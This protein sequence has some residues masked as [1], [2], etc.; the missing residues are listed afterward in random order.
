MLN[1]KYNKHPTTETQEA[2]EECKPDVDFGVRI[3][4][5]NTVSQILYQT[6][7]PWYTFE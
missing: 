6:S 5:F 7:A 2:S 4:S 1:Y 3:F